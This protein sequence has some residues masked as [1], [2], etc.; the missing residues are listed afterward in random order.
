M[1]KQ[2]EKFLKLFLEIAQGELGVKEVAGE[3]NNSRILEYHQTCSLKATSDDISWCSA[4]VNW[5]IKNAGLAG[6]NSAAARS[7]LKWGESTT[8]EKGCIAVLKRGDA[9]WQGH[10]GFCVR[11][12]R[13]DVFILGGNQNDEVNI[14]SFDKY[15]VIGYRLPKL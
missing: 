13:E 8:F 6:T 12:N 14:T 11:E 9:P 10:V 7:W 15:D 2:Q 4:F 1:N 5:V 3:G